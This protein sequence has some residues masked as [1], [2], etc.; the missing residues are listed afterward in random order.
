MAFMFY[1]ALSFDSYI[2]VWNTTSVTDMRSMFAYASSFNQAI[3]AWDTSSVT[4]MN[5]MFLNAT[6]FDRNLCAWGYNF[7]YNNAI[8]I[9]GN[10]GCTFQ[11]E[12]QLE[13]RG[14]F[15]ASSCV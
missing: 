13:G 15:C 6:S 10:S 2:S 14:P 3:A 5:G 1:G 7:P 9:F 11:D 12:P 8:G 4:D